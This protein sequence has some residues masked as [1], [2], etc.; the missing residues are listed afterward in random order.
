M[1]SVAPPSAAQMSAHATTRE[2]MVTDSTHSAARTAT[3]AKT[4]V[5]L[6][7]AG[8]RAGAPMVTVLKLPLRLVD[9]VYGVGQQLHVILQYPGD[10]EWGGVSGGAERVVLQHDDGAVGHG[11]HLGGQGVGGERIDERLAAVGDDQL[12]VIELVDLLSADLAGEAPVLR[13]FQHALRH[14]EAEIDED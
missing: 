13:H 1:V 3:H 2:P 4:Y 12:H 6:S 7:A 9:L 11:R 14:L 10:G 8:R 5:V